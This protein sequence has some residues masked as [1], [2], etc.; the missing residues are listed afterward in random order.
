MPCYLGADAAFALQPDVAA[1]QE[2][3]KK[4]FAEEGAEMYSKLVGVVLNGH[5]AHGKDGQI[6]RD[7]IT[8]NKAA[9]DIA[10]VADSTPASF[11]F[12][13]MSAGAP[14]DDRVTNGMVSS[15]CKF[16]K[17]NISIYDKLTVQETLNVVSACDTII[18]T[19][20]HSS[21]FSVIA[22]RPFVDLIHHD[23]NESFLKTCNLQE[24]GLSYW[25]F[26]TNHLRSLLNKVLEGPIDLS[27]S[28]KS[29]SVLLQESLKYVRFDQSARSGASDIQG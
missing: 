28:K 1:G 6:A 18:S 4:K 24:F 13:P 14:Y 9:Q 11:V 10:T 25:S 7:F 3:L 21:I 27:E 2:L 5:L 20:L 26:G 12:F 22:N 17:K 29:Q 23:K 15:R 19:R 8:L 16:W